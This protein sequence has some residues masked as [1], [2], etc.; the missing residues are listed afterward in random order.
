MIARRKRRWSMVSL[1]CAT[2]LRM[3]LAF[4]QTSVP[5][6]D[7]LEQT[8][9]TV[10]EDGCVQPARLF[11][12]SDYNGPMKK[13]MA[14][15]AR[16]V[17]IKTVQNPQHHLG[18][19]L[20]PLSGEQKFILFVQNSAEPITFITSGFN[21]GTSQAADYDPQFGQGGAGYG[22]RFG[23][24]LADG[25][26]GEFFGTF[27]FPLVFRQDPR[28]YRM[29]EGATK[30]RLGH[31]LAH[32]LITQ[33]DSGTRTFNYSEW[34]SVSSTTALHNIYHPGNHRGFGPTAGRA[35]ITIGTD[36]GF[37]VLREFWP[38][39]SRKL[40]LPFR[41]QPEQRVQSDQK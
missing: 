7:S 27:V 20:C 38:E 31:A 4:A 10:D 18:L 21:A 33:S 19:K 37:T 22:Q 6:V 16:K 40:K 39:I 13:L 30:K 34:L 35:G 2:I 25:V 11:D 15:V 36:A 24:A 17:E 32:V 3:P 12:I 14:S 23:A 9:R 41:R 29:Q 5:Q 28:Y 1:A 26:S 8:G